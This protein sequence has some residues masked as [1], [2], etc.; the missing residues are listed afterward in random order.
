MGLV[1]LN[2]PI[3]RHEYQIKRVCLLELFSWNLN[4]LVVLSLRTATSDGL[5]SVLVFKAL[6]LLHPEVHLLVEW[7]GHLMVTLHNEQI[8]HELGVPACS[9]FMST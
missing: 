4:R 2:H 3:V 5:D 6:Y 7:V 8:A 9:F 1:T